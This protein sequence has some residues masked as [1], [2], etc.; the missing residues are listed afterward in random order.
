SLSHI[1]KAIALPHPQ[2]SDRTPIIPKSHRI[3]YPPNSDRTSQ[4]PLQQRTA[5][6]SASLSHPIIP[7]NSE[8]I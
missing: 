3:P 6:S 5:C 1:L 8:P 2:N 4:H 7:Y